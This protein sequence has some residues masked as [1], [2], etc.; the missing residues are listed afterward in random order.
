MAQMNLF[1][2]QKQTHR[3]GE[4]TCG[5]QGGGGREWGGLRVCSE[6]MQTIPLKWISN[7][8]LLYGIGNYIQSL[9]IEHDRR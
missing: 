4:Q 5:C 8:V 2:E 3:Y 6:Q 7:E 1:I 9:V